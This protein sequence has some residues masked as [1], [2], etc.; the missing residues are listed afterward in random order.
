[1]MFAIKVS[2]NM[3]MLQKWLVEVLF[4]NLMHRIISGKYGAL[5]VV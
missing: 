3:M 2:L 1:M 4:G 5:N